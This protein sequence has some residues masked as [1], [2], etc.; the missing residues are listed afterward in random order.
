MYES[1]SV[2]FSHIWTTR[3]FV[4]HRERREEERAIWKRKEFREVR[5]IEGKEKWLE[6]SGDLVEEVIYFGFTWARSLDSTTVG[7]F[8]TL[9][10]SQCVSPSIQYLGPSRT[11]TNRQSTES[12]SIFVTIESEPM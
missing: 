3:R 10:V 5:M 2:G 12:S 1:E 11:K 7:M 6:G 4:S 8:S 9:S